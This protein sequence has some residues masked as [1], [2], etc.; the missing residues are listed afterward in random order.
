MNIF[1]LK[2]SM[3]IIT[4][5][6]LFAELG[7]LS[8]PNRPAVIPLL[9]VQWLRFTSGKKSNRCRAEVIQVNGH[10]FLLWTWDLK[11]TITLLCYSFSLTLNPDYSYYCDHTALLAS[12]SQNIIKFCHIK[13]KLRGRMNIE[14]ISAKKILL[15]GWGWGWWYA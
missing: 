15:W 13:A 2:F 6:L 3:I 8:E 1:H 14:H 7:S 11:T 9:F 4:K 12:T 5:T 10:H